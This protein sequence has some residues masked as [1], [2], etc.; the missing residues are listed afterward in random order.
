MICRPNVKPPPPMSRDI[1]SMGACVR[2][3]PSSTS[4]GGIGFVTAVHTEE[5]KVDADYI[6]NSI[7]TN[8]TAPLSS[9][10]SVSKSIV[11]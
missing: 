4:Q 11:H 7:H 3:D 8:M 6:Q 2:I 1:F 10:P 9:G 5:R